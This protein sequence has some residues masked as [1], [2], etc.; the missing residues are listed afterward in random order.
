MI[1]IEDIGGRRLETRDHGDSLQ[2]VLKR[3]SR[4]SNLLAG[5][6]VIGGFAF[7]S[8][9]QNSV[10]LLVFAVVGM[11]G[12]ISNRL[13]R[14]ETT[15]RVNRSEVVAQGDLQS[16]SI[17]EMMI[18]LNEITSMGW[19][20]GGQDDSGGLYVANGFT[21]SYILPGATEAQ[22]REI[23][24]AITGRFPGFPIDDK[25][26]ASLIWGDETALT[27]LGLTERDQ[28]EGSSTDK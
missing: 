21:R 4:R 2:F 24:A 5:L 12:L 6:I 19:G 9:W 16:Q 7:V 15:L 17:E 3:N 18:P 8:W 13:R 20:A 10:I 25:T 22:A 23:L 11:I 1:D 28:D 27:E 14:R 26:W